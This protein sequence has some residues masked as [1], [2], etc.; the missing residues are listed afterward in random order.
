MSGD[1]LI[2]VL[3]SCVRTLGMGTSPMLTPQI[4]GRSLGRLECGATGQMGS[5]S[6]S[7]TAEPAASWPVGG[8]SVKVPEDLEEVVTGTGRHPVC[9]GGGALCICSSRKQGADQRQRDQA[10]PAGV[11][12]TLAAL[13]CELWGWAGSRHSRVWGQ[14]GIRWTS[15]LSSKDSAWTS[16][17]YAQWRAEEGS[18]GEGGIG[19]RG[20]PAG[21]GVKPPAPRM[22]VQLHVGLGSDEVRGTDG[23][24]HPPAQQD[25]GT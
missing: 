1:L 25:A 24:P 17:G 9:G 7:R 20:N 14:G 2:L 8:A 15:G 5:C 6:R 4:I 11:G 23:A 13:G 21:L 10:V 16:I 3:S 22:G 19:G 18:R 12:W